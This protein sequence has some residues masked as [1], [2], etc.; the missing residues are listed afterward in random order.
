VSGRRIT[1][2]RPPTLAR[3]GE[4]PFNPKA[5]EPAL[6][7]AVTNSAQAQTAVVYIMEDEGVTLLVD[8]ARARDGA[9]STPSLETVERLA[10]IGRGESEPLPDL[11]SA[12]TF[13]G[14]TQV[15]PCPASIN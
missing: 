3:C 8:A 11:S 15:S 4:A 10:G 7:V 12:T 5:A 14:K 9:Q 1:Q 2:N 13:G 6:K